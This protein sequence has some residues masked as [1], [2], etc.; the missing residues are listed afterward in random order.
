MINRIFK[1][2]GFSVL[3]I[4]ILSSVSGFFLAA[5]IARATISDVVGQ[6]FLANSIVSM[7]GVFGIFGLNQVASKSISKHLTYE[8]LYEAKSQAKL[9]TVA[10]LFVSLLTSA[11][12]MLVTNTIYFNG[13]GW[14]GE[15]SKNYGL[16]VI[17]LVLCVLQT[18]QVEIYRAHR[19]VTFSSL[20]GGLIATTITILLIVG[21]NFIYGQMK[22]QELLL[23]SVSGIFAQVVLGYWFSEGIF[24]NNES[25]RFFD[26]CKVLKQGL[27]MLMIAIFGF[28]ATQ[29][30]I[31]L[32]SHFATPGELANYAVAAKLANLT[33]F[34][35][36]IFYALLPPIIV[37]MD[38]KNDFTT[39]EKLL[40]GC[41]AINTLIMMPF[42][43]SVVFF[44]K[45]LLALVFGQGYADGDHILII[46]ALGNFVNLVTGIRGYVL[47]LTG[48]HRV[49]MAITILSACLTMLLGYIC[50]I[51]YGGIG[52]IVGVTIS[53]IF[54]CIIELAAVKKYKK[55]N[56]SIWM[57]GKES[58]YTSWIFLN[59][60]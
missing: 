24:W 56:T 53:T 26:I 35:S 21:F 42:F 28:V 60:R 13:S 48:H 57:V 17:W 7:L 6:F 39:L 32:V 36:A 44:P 23:L 20:F 2:T 46:V 34:V 33:N 1:S 38:I 3:C 19:K 47:I 58:I 59:E 31:F 11:L 12:Y 29:S 10:S 54:Q 52:V 8:D 51:F 30:G 50:G 49:Q 40:K 43:I 18:L 37:K 41:A 9:I 27:P 22:L 5:V 45:G 14:G 4:K 55:I 25:F 16:M 15:S